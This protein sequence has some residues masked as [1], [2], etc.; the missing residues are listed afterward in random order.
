M[1]NPLNKRLPRE[2]TGE[3]GKYLVIFLFMAAT[4]GFVSGFLVAG[5]SMIKAY[6]DSF[7]T[8]NIEDG[9]FVLQE[10][11][12][13]EVLDRLEEN[14]KI[15][16]D[17]YIDA[18]TNTDSKVRIFKKREIVNLEDLME[19]AFPE[20]DN[21]IALDRMYANNNDIQVGDRIT[22]GDREL[23]VTG[24]VALSD[25]SALFSDNSDM[26]FDAVK[27][28]V[29]IMTEEGFDHFDTP[30]VHYN[31]SWKYNPVPVDEIAE[32]EASDDFLELLGENV[33]VTKYVPRYSNQ[34]INFTGEDMGGDRTMMIVLLYIL[35]I[36]LAFVFS[37]T[38]NHT[39]V[40]E[41]AVIGTLRASGYTKGEMLKHYLTLPVL[42]T[43]AAALVGNIL[44]YTLFK[45]IVAAMYY[46][47]YSLP[48]YK[49]I[50]NGEAFVLT[51]IIPILIM[52]VANTVVLI[53]RLAFS[54]LAF[55]RHD[56][57]RKHKEKAIRLPAFKFFNRFR[58][59]IML[60][61]RSSYLTLFAG[62]V[63]ANILLLFGMMMGPLL[64]HYQ[65]EISSNMLADYQY[66]LKAPVEAEDSSAEKYSVTSLK[67][68]VDDNDGEEVSAYGI[69]EN[70]EYVKAGL[71]SEGVSI[72]VGMAEKYRLHEGDRITL[73]EAYGKNE[74][75]FE[76]TGIYDYPAAMA[77]FM[78]AEEFVKVFDKE[79]DYFNGYFS[80]KELSDI[81]ENYIASCITEEDLTKVSRQL[82]LS[83][84]KMFY[85]INVFAIILAALLIYL[86]TKLIV[87]KN[88]TSISMVKILGYENS[89]IGRLY[90]M[91]TTWVVIFSVVISLVISTWVIKALFRMIIKDFSGWLTFYIAPQIYGE[92]FIIV[93]VVYCIVALLQFRRIERIPMD[94]ALKNVE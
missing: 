72:S 63:F 58:L 91:A 24:L 32:K 16:P 1:R 90:L 43:L 53:R 74:Y 80:N 15:Y 23:K 52:A 4:I 47:S 40:K 36:I 69:A 22:S 9:H 34:A 87:E 6:N 62:I 83:M 2:F 11:A 8:Y 27:F 76:I 85:M 82:D 79:A 75:S 31:Y 45:N 21:E 78:P 17:F 56:L 92:M 20:K 30:I 41:S 70:S 73:R 19:G 60:Q 44:G 66:I 48:T 10:A 50:W 93:M 33:A 67:Y 94:E 12:S 25:Y 64:S 65:K 14:V 3:I 59:R 38:I 5:G 35:I 71:D 51:T 54:P 49:T 84:G 86:L 57:S 81:D 7:E 28:G 13:E 29:A 77:V 46:N 42:V 55:L 26:M 39:I 89:E 61:N 88:T 68:F 37:V 18:D